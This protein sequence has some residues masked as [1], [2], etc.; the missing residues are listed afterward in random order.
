MEHQ[1]LDI[2]TRID[3]LEFMHQDQ[4]GKMQYRQ[5]GCIL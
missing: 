5:L 1:D 4:R 3:I 2:E